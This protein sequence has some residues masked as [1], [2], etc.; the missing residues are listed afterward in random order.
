M[1][2]DKVWIFTFIVSEPVPVK[3]GLRLWV[4]FYH[5]QV[6][7][8]SEPVPV[9]EGLRPD[10]ALL[11]K[12]ISFSVSEPVPVKEGLRLCRGFQTSQSLASQRASSSE[13]RIKT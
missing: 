1:E 2:R 13:R 8:V 11:S 6:V 5:F 7:F 9:K 10:S 4:D 3:E 12:L